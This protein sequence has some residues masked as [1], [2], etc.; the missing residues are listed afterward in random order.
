MLPGTL[1]INKDIKLFYK[2]MQQCS[3]QSGHRID[4]E[5]V[6]SLSNF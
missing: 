3:V 2:Y 1:L 6:N 5:H 4:I